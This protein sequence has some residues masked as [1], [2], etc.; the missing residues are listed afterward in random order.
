MEDI[1]NSR[2]WISI[3]IPIPAQKTCKTHKSGKLI[4]H[5][6][7]LFKEIAYK[8]SEDLICNT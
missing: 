4:S 1:G 6:G 8:K 2:S 3:P 7:S 5:I